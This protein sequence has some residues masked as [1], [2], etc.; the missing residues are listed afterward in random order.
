MNP[1]NTTVNKFVLAAIGMAVVLA[2]QW[3]H[4]NWMP[5]PA[6]TNTIAGLVTP[7]LIYWIANKEPKA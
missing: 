5:D 6:I 1:L 2:N 7:P 3:F 4:Q